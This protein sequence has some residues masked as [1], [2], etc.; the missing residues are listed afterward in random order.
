M[1]KIF[2]IIVSIALFSGCSG[3]NTTTDTKVNDSDSMINIV[4]RQNELNKSSGLSK[5]INNDSVYKAQYGNQIWMTRN[6]SVER[7]NNGEPIKHVKSY[8]EWVEAG[9]NKQATWY[10]Y[11]DD[12]IN[13]I[14]H[15]KLYNFYAVNDARG[16]APNGWSIPTW[17]DWETLKEYFRENRIFADNIKSI[18]DWSEDFH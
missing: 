18:S 9:I 6:L 2:F 16:L 13:E 14:K 15:G 11:D 12:P 10:Y 5:F 17:E 3:S 1:Y 4:A 8:Q 7:F